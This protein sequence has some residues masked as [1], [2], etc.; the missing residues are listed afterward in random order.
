MPGWMKRNMVYREGYQSSEGC[1]HALTHVADEHGDENE[2]AD[3]EDGFDVTLDAEA[4]GG[5]GGG[6]CTVPEEE[7]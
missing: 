6:A 4:M 2:D 3:S 5:S 7:R 1:Q